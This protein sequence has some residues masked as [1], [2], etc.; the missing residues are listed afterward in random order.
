MPADPESH[1]VVLVT[2]AAGA[3]GVAI[4]RQLAARPEYDVVLL[5]RRRDQ[6]ERARAA[7]AQATRRS[8][9]RVEQADLGRRADIEA[10]AARWTGPLHVLVNNAATAPRQ[11]TETPEGIEAQLATNILGYVWMMAAFAPILERSRPA[12]VVNV[13]S[14]WAGDLDVD[15]LEFRRRRYDNDTAYRQSKQ[16]NRMLTVT[17]AERLAPRGITVNACHPGDVP[18]KLSHDLGFGGSQSPDQGADTPVW[19]ATAA[20]VAAVTGGYFAGRRQVRDP[21]AADRH[22]LEALDA[23]CQALSSTSQ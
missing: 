6:A 14:Y 18:S 17:W 2:G 11:R 13:A 1:R 4:A 10:L 5:A 20:E 7:V 15:D 22:T 8:D 12:R 16:A 21:F 23:R 19:L 3:I 9:L